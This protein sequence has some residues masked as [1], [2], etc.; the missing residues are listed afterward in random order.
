MYAKFANLVLLAVIW[1]NFD[2][3]VVKL[4][5]GIWVYDGSFWNVLGLCWEQTVWAVWSATL[6]A[7]WGST[8][9][10]FISLLH[11]WSTFLFFN[12]GIKCSLQDLFKTMISNARR[13]VDNLLS[14]PSR[15]SRF[16]FSQVSISI[17][18]TEF[19]NVSNIFFACISNW[20]WSLLH[21]VFGGQ[22]GKS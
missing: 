9:R 11:G 17:V 19:L 13:S 2:F 14:K 18:I 16:D 12:I 6:S 22:L 5:Y 4:N 10:S 7:F 3:P 20:G 1:P 21:L 15:S 8:A